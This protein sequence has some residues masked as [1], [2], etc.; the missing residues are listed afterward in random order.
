MWCWRRMENISWTD[1][2]RNEE[3]LQKGKERNILQVIK[4]KVKWIFNTLRRNCLIK[5]IIE[6]KVKG[7]I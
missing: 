7:R 6:G 4:R 3:M 2:V 5:H 1:G